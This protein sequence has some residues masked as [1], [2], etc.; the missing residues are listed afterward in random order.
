MKINSHKAPTALIQKYIGSAYDTVK[1]VADNLEDLLKLVDS[2]GLYLGAQPNP[3]TV[4]LND[5]PL[6]EGNYYLNS[7]DGLLYFYSGSEWVPYSFEDIQKV[8]RF[9]D[10]YLP[11][12]G[13]PTPSSSTA[14][15]IWLC[16]ETGTISGTSVEV[17]EGSYLLYS[18]EN[19][20]GYTLLNQKGDKGDKG[21][22]GD[23]G[24]KGDKG[25][26]GDKGDTG[27]IPLYSGMVNAIDNLD[28][29]SFDDIFYVLNEGK[30]YRLSDSQDT[31][32]TSEELAAGKWANWIDPKQEAALSFKNRDEVK[33]RTLSGVN[34]KLVVLKPNMVIHTT[35]YE[36]PG[37]GGGAS[38]F[39]VENVFPS[40]NPYIDIDIP[41]TN[42]YA[43]YLGSSISLAQAG[44]PSN[45]VLGLV[46]VLNS[47]QSSRINTFYV[48]TMYESQNLP[49]K[50]GVSFIGLDE[51][52]S[53]FFVTDKD[54]NIG[55]MFDS[56]LSVDRA[57]TVF[58]NIR[59][60]RVS[61]GDPLTPEIGKLL[62]LSKVSNVEFKNCLFE[63]KANGSV[64]I[65]GCQDVS[66]TNCRVVNTTT[67]DVSSPG[68]LGVPAFEL[69]APCAGV[70]IEDNFITSHYAGVLGRY[71][72]GEAPGFNS[73]SIKRNIMTSIAYNGIC[74]DDTLNVTGGGHIVQQLNVEFNTVVYSSS[75]AGSSLLGN[76]ARGTGFYGTNLD[77]STVSHNAFTSVGTATVSNTPAAVILKNYFRKLVIEDNNINGGVYGGILTSSSAPDSNCEVLHN[78]ITHS[79][80]YKG[81][82]VLSSENTSIHNNS[83]AS[84]ATAIDVRALEGNCNNVTITYNKTNQPINLL[85]VDTYSVKD[86]TIRGSVV[87]EPL[88]LNDC[89]NGIIQGNIIY[90]NVD[91]TNGI[92]EFI[93]GSNALITD[94]LLMSS[95]GVDLPAQILS[96]G[97]V[98]NVIFKDNTSNCSKVVN[99]TGTGSVKLDVTHSDIPPNSIFRVGDIVRVETPVAAGHMGKV[100]VAGGTST[101]AV[102]KKFGAVEA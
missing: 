38:Y 39:I 98:S 25:D 52:N 83:I 28:T 14:P 99:G 12:E 4:G 18:P 102:F 90:K 69:V 73:I 19:G 75:F 93:G 101:S 42:L 34:D 22:T 30:F 21:D 54:F 61:T 48:G 63:D 20:G 67:F 16:A 85:Q 45:D 77:G 10:T 33:T 44:A 95:S 8:L 82:S 64:K 40:F 56:S 72:S 2:V 41:G 53:G 6:T 49:F 91:N 13:Y 7:T 89:E 66:I 27:A 71:A 35:G 29:L 5:Q 36:T 17:T 65:S 57:K 9:G 79:G 92:I 68:S 78:K 50:E 32:T 26:A 23:K 37:D 60:S 62:E 46:N 87:D 3:P 24:D 47:I 58:E 59:F 97:N 31:S 43:I 86:N 81:I 1:Y 80:S 96:A 15:E 94:N 100:C 11:S 51:F 88:V 55:T 84:G 70:V 74:F 76:Q